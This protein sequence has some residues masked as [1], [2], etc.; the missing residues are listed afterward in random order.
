LYI[1]IATILVVMTVG[2]VILWTNSKTTLSFEILDANSRNW[3]WDTTAHLQNRV[4]HGYYTTMYHFTKLSP[5]TFDLTVSA[6]HYEQAKVKVHIRAGQD[7]RIPPISLLGYGIPGYS[8]FT[9]AADRTARGLELRLTPMDADGN[10]IKI[11][12]CLD[13]KI[14]VRVFIQNKG[15]IPALTPTS[16]GAERGTKL[17]EG[18]IDWFWNPATEAIF[19]YSALIPGISPATA[20][21][22]VVDYV[23]VLP[24][25]RKISPPDVDILMKEL[26]QHQDM[27]PSTDDLRPH[28]GKIKIESGTLWNVQNAAGP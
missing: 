21:Y 20:P 15:G 28:S 9:L 14:A 11:F 7:N 12:P 25:P 18:T 5:G 17:F 26:F 24:D 27:M 23:V 2:T 1:T 10:L 4:I 8:K 22:I 13:L 16:D 6:P 3:V 19:R